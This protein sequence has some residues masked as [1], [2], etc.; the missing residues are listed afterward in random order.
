MSAVML[1]T[2]MRSICLRWGQCTRKGS[3]SLSMMPRRTAINNFCRRGQPT[4]RA[5]RQSPGTLTPKLPT[6]I[7]FSYLLGVTLYPWYCRLTN[8]EMGAAYSQHIETV[9][10]QTHTQAAKLI[11]LARHRLTRIT[12]S[13]LNSFSRQGHFTT[14]ITCTHFP[15]LIIKQNKAS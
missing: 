13:S 10:W 14:I 3:R 6:I 4:A 11:T 9:A 8:L 7:T 1:L 2:P 12:Q 15:K 5:L